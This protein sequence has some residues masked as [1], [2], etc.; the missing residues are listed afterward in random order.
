MSSTSGSI[1]KITKCSFKV[2]QTDVTRKGNKVNK[3]T[4]KEKELEKVETFQSWLIKHWEIMSAAGIVPLIMST[5]K[6]NTIYL[7]SKWTLEN[8]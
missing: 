8:Y 5:I 2:K 4:Q 3:T 7:I 6:Q 1:I